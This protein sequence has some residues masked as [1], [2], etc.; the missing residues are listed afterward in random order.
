[1]MSSSVGV[2]IPGDENNGVDGH[3][4]LGDSIEIAPTPAPLDGELL[5]DTMRQFIS[6][7][8][9]HFGGTYTGHMLAAHLGDSN[10]D[11]SQARI[12]IADLQRQLSA[13]SE[14]LSA[15]KV[16]AASLRERISGATV[17]IWFQK[18]CAFATPIAFSFAIDLD[19]ANMSMW[20]AS[21]LLGVFLF[22]ISIFPDLRKKL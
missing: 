7:N 13:M 9:A 10:Y 20:K 17:R 19:K 3:Q 21:A 1:M 15:E 22:V 16:L 6:G 14:K 2:P 8:P 5:V 18:I 12:Q 11:K 4:Q